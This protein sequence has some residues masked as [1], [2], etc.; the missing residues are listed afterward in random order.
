MKKI[1]FF[2]LGLMLFSACSQNTFSPDSE[3]I[4]R[5]KFED[6]RFEYD[7]TSHTMSAFNPS[8][9]GGSFTFKINDWDINRRR[10]NRLNLGPHGHDSYSREYWHGI[11]LKVE[12]NWDGICDYFYITLN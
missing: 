5:F 6:V 8:S 7:W 3:G 9:S 1:I 10:G 4:T 2:I 11:N 12:Y